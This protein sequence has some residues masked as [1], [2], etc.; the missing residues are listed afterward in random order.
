M[1]EMID[2]IQNLYDSLQEQFGTPGDNV[3]PGGLF[4][5]FEKLGIGLSANDFKLQP[6]DSAFN[7]AIAAQHESTL[8][9]FVAQLD[10][11]GFI[12]PRGDLSPTV[13]GQYGQI[14]STASY[15][16]Q[17]AS[18]A[19]LTAFLQ[20]KGA[21]LRTLDESKLPAGLAQSYWT[22]SFV[23]AVWYDD[24]DQT[25][26]QT[27]SSS[28]GESTTPPAPTPP[29]P[30]PP[31]RIQ[32]EWSWR[33]VTP[34]AAPQVAA[35]RTLQAVPA[36]QRFASDILL[37]PVAAQPQALAPQATASL[38]APTAMARVAL[39]PAMVST[40]SSASRLAIRPATGLTSLSASS[41]RASTLDTAEL[42]V[43]RVATP[44][45]VGTEM[46]LNPLT[47]TNAALSSVVLNLPA[48]PTS[49]MNFE[50]SFKY[51]VASV[52][53]PWLSS[54]FL[55]AANWYVPG[56]QSGALAQGLYAKA[57]QRFGFLPAKLLVVKELSIRAEWSEQDRTFAQNSAS[58]GPFSLIN[59][60]FDKN[61]LTAPGMQ[62]IGWF[63]QVV[64]V[65]PPMA[66]PA[67]TGAAG[68]TS[69]S[70]PRTGATTGT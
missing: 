34:E 48:Q 32:R 38:I 50:I 47:A 62:V 31:I 10:S 20:S 60:S 25:I 13:T 19:A 43:E 7:P 40:Q 9:N 18:D 21:A 2:L 37:T 3:G 6:T 16:V 53:R 29:A 52:A 1:A 22:A 23:P 46:R 35:I 54:D 67:A 14:L 4:L 64:P 57:A 44:E 45:R 49:S 36:N 15:G 65:L 27:Y 56:L 58:L 11:D 12:L 51:C 26:W 28:T 61:E 30:T 24:Q 8:V 33:V 69:T 55:T 59:S 17:P 63:C 41:V 5:A 70:D 39:S 68:A 66:D 42:P